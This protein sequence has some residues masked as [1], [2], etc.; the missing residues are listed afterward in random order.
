VSFNWFASLSPFQVTHISPI[1][2]ISVENYQNTAHKPSYKEFH[3]SFPTRLREPQIRAWHE[4]ASFSDIKLTVQTCIPAALGGLLCIWFLEPNTHFDRNCLVT[5]EGYQDIRGI[6]PTDLD[7]KSVNYLI[8]TP[9]GNIYHS[10]DS[11][12]SIYYAKPARTTP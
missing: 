1:I 4:I 3:I 7:E 11:H 8:K 5:T 6:C 2:R 10:S 12:Y 9:G